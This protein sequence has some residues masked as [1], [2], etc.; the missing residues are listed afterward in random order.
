MLIGAG[1][2]LGVAG[3]AFVGYRLAKGHQHNGL[4]EATWDAATNK[5]LAQLHPDFA[6]L[7]ARFINTVERQL[8]I[9]LR[10][11]REGGYRSL[12]RQAELYAQGRTAPGRIV[13]NARPG[14]SY[15]NYGLAVDVVEIKDGRAI[16]DN[17]RLQEIAAIGKSLGMRWGGDFRS[18]KDTPHY[19]F[20]GGFSTAELLQRV[21]RG[22]TIGPYPLL[23]S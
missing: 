21:Q 4:I 22:H 14:K 15:H 3:A 20:S 7:A 1:I 19:E 18:I 13:T 8:G 10:I 11:P 12:Q 5:Q 23:T 9:R 16:W 17:P 6:P 2:A